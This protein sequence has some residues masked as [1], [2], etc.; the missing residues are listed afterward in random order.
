M[1]FKTPLVLLALVVAGGALWMFAGDKTG[2]AQKDDAPQ[3]EPRYVFEAKPSGADITR[4]EI[5]TPGKPKLV[6]SRPAPK[7]A[8]GKTED[9]TMLEPLASATESYMVNGIVTMLTGL[10]YSR[11]FKPGAGGVGLAEAGLEPP[12][13]TFKIVDKEGKEFGLAVGKRAPLS[14]DMFVRVTGADDIRVVQRDLS[15]DIKKA[16][17]D[18]R[19]K[20]LVKGLK[21]DSA[22]RILIEHESKRF[23]LTKAPDGEWVFESPLKTF[24]DKKKVQ[25]LLSAFS[26]L[27]VDTFVED[28]PPSLDAFGLG[29]PGLTIE[30]T[31]EEE[32]IPPPR[33]GP[34]RSPLSRRSRRT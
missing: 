9:W 29:K 4:L 1:S 6:F 5:E 23:E 7:E 18:F 28:A 14:N 8:G 31:T 13:A 25:D 19:A 27:R 21:R 22:A 33:R 26:G 15:P 32:R 11:S 34:S 3:S 10:Q 30:V 24:A 2:D 16:A 20:N 12:E 17:A